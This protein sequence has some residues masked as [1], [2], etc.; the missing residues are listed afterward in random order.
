MMNNSTDLNEMAHIL[1]QNDNFILISHINPDGDNIGSMVGLYLALKQKNKNVKVINADST[2]KKYQFLTKCCPIGSLNELE[3]IKGPIITLDC[4]DLSRTG[5]KD[6]D[7]IASMHLIINIDHHISNKYFG[8]YNLVDAHAAATGEIIFNLI[9]SMEVDITPEIATA[10]YT[11]I[12]TDTGSFRFTNT[13]AFSLETAGFLLKSG[14]DLAVINTAVYE[15]YSLEYMRFLGFAL[16]QLELSEDGKIAWIE[17]KQEMLDKF[18]TKKDES[19]GLVN[20]AKSIDG[21][22]VAFVINQLPDN[23]YKVSFRSK[24]NVDVNKIAGNFGGGGHQKAAGCIVGHYP[25]SK[26]LREHIVTE[27]KKTGV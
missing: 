17:I 26:I 20:Y 19:E 4:T 5:I 18:N 25:T 21:V 22:E 6:I 7:K 3:N 27:I 24:G 16:G 8:N 13:T 14:A 12:M 1:N 10:L 23:S 11:A 9:K 15:T 2:P